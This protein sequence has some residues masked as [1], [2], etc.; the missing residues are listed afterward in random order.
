M[1]CRQILDMD[2]ELNIAIRLEVK[3]F[4]CLLTEVFYSQRGARGIRKSIVRWQVWQQTKQRR[5]E[6]CKNFRARKRWQ[7]KVQFFFS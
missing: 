4:D 1:C 7:S 2:R 5:K 6:V 3:R